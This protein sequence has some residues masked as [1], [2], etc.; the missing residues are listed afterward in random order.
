MDTDLRK[1][2]LS[3]LKKY[4]Q[5]I[6]KSSFLQEGRFIIFFIF[7]IISSVFW[8]VRALGE[9]YDTVVE[10]PVRYINFPEDKVLIGEVPE[11]LRL[12]VRASGFT[13][14]KSKLNL[15]IAP[16]RFNVN[17]FSLNSLGTDTFYVITETIRNVLSDE[18]DNTIITNIAPDTLFFRFSS[19]AIK[20]VAVKPLLVIHNKFFQQQYMQNGKIG[21]TPDSIIISGPRY[22]INDIRYVSTE[23]LSFNN[24]RDTLISETR[25]KPVELITFSQQKVRITIPVDRFTEVEKQL[26]LVTIN[27]PDSLNMVAI[28]GQVTVTY[29]VCLSSYNRVANT[30]I[31]PVVDYFEIRE[32]TLQRLTVFLT[33]TPDFVSNVHINPKL[34]EFLIT[35][36]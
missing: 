10:Y 12:T 21:V 25:L 26:P 34:T 6:T 14:L 22:L 30:P 29:R 27:V 19:L 8:F 5:R 16:L 1:N 9:Q 24:L 18:L 23:P 7:V 4:L 33:D 28:P 20:R 35:R 36:K 3:L 2:L 11:K 17:S 31:T 13:V 15:N 32:N